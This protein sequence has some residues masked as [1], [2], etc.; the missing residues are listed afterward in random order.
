MIYCKVGKELLQT[1]TAFL[2]HKAKQLVLQNGTG[3]AK[4]GNFIKKMGQVLQRGATFII[5]WGNY[6]KVVQYRRKKKEKGKDN[7]F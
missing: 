3:F 6:Y 2:Y 7:R 4:W 1:G 5:K